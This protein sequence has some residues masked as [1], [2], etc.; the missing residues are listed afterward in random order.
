MVLPANFAIIGRKPRDDQN[1]FPAKQQ[2][3]QRSDDRQQASQSKD[4]GH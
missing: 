4:N 2:R 1:P 3:T